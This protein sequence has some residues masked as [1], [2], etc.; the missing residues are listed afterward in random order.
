M[1][2]FFPCF[3]VSI[4]LSFLLPDIHPAILSNQD[5]EQ[6]EWKEKQLS[7]KAGSVFFQDLSFGSEYLLEVTAVNSNGSSVPA[8]FNFTI[9]EQHGSL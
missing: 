2:L 8:K 4:F 5:E 3:F 6:A 1:Y 7:S 9:A